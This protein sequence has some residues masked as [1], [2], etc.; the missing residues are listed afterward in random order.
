MESCNTWYLFFCISQAIAKPA[1][2]QTT[3]D[4]I[5]NISLGIK[6]ALPAIITKAKKQF[7]FVDFD[8]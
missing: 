1:I 7:A 6:M 4:I 5:I 8:G 3:P 2:T